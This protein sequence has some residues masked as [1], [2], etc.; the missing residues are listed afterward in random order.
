MSTGLHTSRQRGSVI[1]VT[2]WTV[3]LLTILITVIA[4]QI[5][6]SARAAYYQQEELGEWASIVSAVNQA[7]MELIMERMPRPPETIDDLDEINRN[8]LFRFNGQELSLH[9]PQAEGITIRIYDHAGKINLREIGRPRMRAL[10]EKKLG[11]DADDQI[12]ELIAAWGD[13]VD[14]S[15]SAGINGA[16][17]DYYEALDN[18]Y[19]PRN[20]KLE[21][22]EEIL[23]I[24]GFDEVFADVDL[25]AAFTLYTD[26]ELVNLNL[27]TVEAMQLLP[28]LDDELIAEIVAFRENNE[29]RGNGD[30]AQIVPAENMAELRP[31]LNSRRTTSYYT[32]M[33]Y[34]KNSAEE[35]LFEDNE[36]VEVDVTK[37]AF[38]EIVEIRSVND[39]PKVLK[40][41]PYQDI[42]IRL[43]VRTED[44]MFE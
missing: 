41:N 23:H 3:I 40:I 38:S 32:I 7:E 31:W 25:D 18:P 16:E 21:T 6:L 13:W 24:R 15:D 9:Y 29:F 27:A 2:L 28:G 20:G 14:L 33:A 5:R 22:V 11:E 12:D 44:E 30:V 34:R 43:V 37:T 36:P 35:Y 10:L 17:R 8:P 19:S 1:V 39:R 26:D 42:P 4:G